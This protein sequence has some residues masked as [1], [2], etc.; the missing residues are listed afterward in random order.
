M[1]FN[2]YSFYLNGEERIY[3]TSVTHSTD[4]EILDWAVRFS[5]ID[6][7]DIEKCSKI[8]ALTPGEVEQRDKELFNKWCQKYEDD[9]W[10][11]ESL[12]RLRPTLGVQLD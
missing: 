11:G 1:N 12:W 6:E 2:Y 9:T 5:F 10:C 4:D 8:R 7:E 3:Y